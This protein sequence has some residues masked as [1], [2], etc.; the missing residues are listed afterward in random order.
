MISIYEPY[1]TEDIKKYAHDAIESSWISSQGKY[2][3]LIS[4]LLMDIN[5]SKN[6]LLCNNGTSATHLMAIGLK[7][8]HP[9]IKNIIVPNNVYV[10][11]WNCFLMN[12]V[13]NL[14]PVDC[15]LDTWNYDLDEL[16]IILNE[17][18]P[19]DTAVLI[20]HNIGNILNLPLLKGKYKDYVFLEDNCEGFL[21]KYTEYPSGSQSLMSSTSFF[22][23]KTITSGEG[24]ALFTDDDELAE[25]LNSVRTQ[26]S[27][28]YKFVFDKL[29]Y[30]YRM[31]NVQAAILYG[32]LLH[33]DEILISKQRVFSIYKRLLSDFTFQSTEID[34]VHSNWMLGINLHRDVRDISLRLFQQG[35]ETRPMFYPMSSHK[36]LTQYVG[37]EENARVLSKNCLIFP[38]HPALQ[39]NQ[40]EFICQILRG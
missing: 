29:G 21:G 26:G 24:G 33:L 22:A 19:E 9:K 36:H 5:G 1:L 10:A 20:V 37:K 8:K 18:S 35:I 40:I 34:T 12:P 2:L 11:A 3:S 30:N 6:V 39:F 4:H 38:S 14:I 28:K 17:Y 15:S 7:F 23:N 16:D 32:Q 31:T 25:Y 13:Y 27:T